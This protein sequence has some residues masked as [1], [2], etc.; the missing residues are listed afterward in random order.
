MRAAGSQTQTLAMGDPPSRLEPHEIEFGSITDW[1]ARVSSTEVSKSFLNQ[2]VMDYLLIEG[3]KDAAECF[4]AESGTQRKIIVRDFS[5][6][7]P[8]QLRSGSR[9]RFDQREGDD[10]RLHC[11]W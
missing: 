5:A 8:D 4:A 2:L 3:F 10:S 6:F 7:S 11:E 9:H 1:S